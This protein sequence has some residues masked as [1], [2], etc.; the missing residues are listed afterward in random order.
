LGE[1]KTKKMIWPFNLFE[2][3]I[4]E[5][6][7]S[8]R[9]SLMQALLFPISFTFLLT[10]TLSR[11]VNYTWPTMYFQATP[12]LHIHHFTYG[13]IILA[14][15]GFLSLLFSGPRGKFW[16]AMLYGTG[17]GFAFDEFAMW[18]RLDETDPVR[19]DYDGFVIIAGIFLM[20]FTI[21]QGLHF[22]RRLLYGKPRAKRSKPH[23]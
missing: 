9:S 21:P 14:A 1:S 7:I 2:K 16:I 12:T 8:K 3:E 22:I 15:A 17:L 20:L 19:W 5:A 6:V 4:E 10:F 13:I 18:L 11:I 23:K